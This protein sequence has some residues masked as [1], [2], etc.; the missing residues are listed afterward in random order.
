MESAK[1]RQFIKRQS[2]AEHVR[3]IL[4]ER[5]PAAFAGKGE[6]K[7]PLK[8]GIAE[9]LL[10]A[11]PELTR[12][13][14]AFALADYTWGPTYCRHVI[15]GAARIGLDGAPCG[16][17]SEAEAAFATDRLKMLSK[18][19]KPKPKPAQQAEGSAVDG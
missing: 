7:K 5:F 3:A 4:V 2:I 8:I 15:A 9:D 18:K 17:V 10:L 14:L 19:H 13:N 6:E 1:R 11:M 12:R 16:T